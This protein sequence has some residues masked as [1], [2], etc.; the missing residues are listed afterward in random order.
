MIKE[1]TKDLKHYILRVTTDVKESTSTS[2]TAPV[3][4]PPWC[5]ENLL[6]SRA[7]LVLLLSHSTGFFCKEANKL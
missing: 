6:W 7:S 2:T 3:F 4:L 5:L 1:L